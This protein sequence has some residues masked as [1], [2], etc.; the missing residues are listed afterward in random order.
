MRRGGCSST[1]CARSDGLPP[2]RPSRRATTRSPRPRPRPGATPR[3]RSAT[4]W[5]AARRTRRSSS[6]TS[7]PS[8]RWSTRAVASSDGTTRTWAAATISP[9]CTPGSRRRWRRATPAP[10]SGTRRIATWPRTSSFA[11][12][13]AA[14]SA[15]WSSAGRSTIRSRASAKRRPDGRSCSSC[16]RA[17]AF[18]WSRTPRRPRPASTT[19]STRRPR[20]R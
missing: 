13:R 14:S 8:S 4:T 11:T 3:P 5:S 15:P 16:P 20:T 18:R 1:A 9:A 17:T 19:A 10:T 7:R 12:T 2:W 6:E